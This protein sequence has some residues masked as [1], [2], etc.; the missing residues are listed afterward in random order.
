MASPNWLLLQVKPRQELRALENLERQQAQCYCPK[1][2]VE[3]LRCGKR[4]QV[5]EVLFAGYIFINAQSQQN[6]HQYPF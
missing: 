5:K 4:I 6:I 3:K 1:I 2:Q